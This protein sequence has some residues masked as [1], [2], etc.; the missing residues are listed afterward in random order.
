MHETLIIFMREFNARVRTRAFLI[1]TFLAPA[2]TMAVLSL[3]LIGGGTQ[4]TLVVVNEAAPEIGASF[5]QLLTA[6]PRSERDNAYK[7]EL[8][9]GS[10]D[11]MR[12]QLDAEV[13]AERIDG[14]VVIPRDVLDKPQIAYRARNA[15]GPAMLQELERAG[16]RATQIA[17]ITAVGIPESQLQELLRGV[18]VQTARL[19]PAGERAESAAIAIIVAY[20]TAFASYF[21]IIGYG[22]SILRSVL[23]EKTSRIAEIVLSSVPAGRF[24]GGKLLGAAG[25]AL[26]QIAMWTV[27]IALVV[28]AVIA[29]DGS[30]SVRKLLDSFTLPPAS[31]WLWLLVF[32]MLGFM[33]YGSLFAA[34]GAA[35]TTEQ[36][37]Q[38]L[39]NLGVLPILIPLVMVFR[40]VEAPSGALATTLSLVPLTS[41]ITMPIRMVAAPVPAW[42][43]AAA[44]LLLLVGFVVITWGAGKVFR[45]GVLNVG[46]KATLPEIWRWLRT[47]I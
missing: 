21:L 35:V 23:E 12:L 24:L 44:L 26:L 46:R 42:Q 3:Q 34:I 41:P 38:S 47:A 18:K 33:L 31:L 7:A 1:G 15:A 43:L 36:E 45:I 25:A 4:R 9:N 13:L 29:V 27:M 40:I 8:R 28:A 16:A 2:L 14:Y 11:E 22:L 37:A 6:P 39:Q 5:V 19:T 20:L 10:W 32:V 30:G 17:R